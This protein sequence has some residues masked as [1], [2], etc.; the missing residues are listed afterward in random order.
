MARIVVALG[1]NALQEKGET[2]AESQMVVAE[3]TAKQLIG[4]I[5]GGHDL[6]IVHGNGPQIGTILQKEANFASEENPAMPLDTCVAMSQGSIGYWLQLALNNVLEKNK[7]NRS[8]LTIVTE[9]LIDKKDP[10]FKDPTKPVGLFYE[11]SKDALAALKGEDIVVKEDAGR[12]W[13]RVVPSPKPLDIIEKKQI[14]QLLE[15]GNIVITGGGGGVPVHRQSDGRL[16]GVEAVVDK[17]F[18]AAKVAENINADVLLIL[19]AVSQVMI[20]FGKP[21]AMPL[22]RATIKEL[23]HYIH[24]EQFAPGSMLPKIEASIEFVT[25]GVNRKTIITTPYEASD[26]IKGRAGT[27][28]GGDY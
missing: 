13:R 20:N 12:G 23:K 10:A 19:T 18:V 24:E 6:A 22:P 21:S 9:V 5:K 4:L 7:I 16:V 8:A 14:N 2:S 27:Q 11:S 17:D 1:G 15:Y 26:A 28:I 25:S 3:K